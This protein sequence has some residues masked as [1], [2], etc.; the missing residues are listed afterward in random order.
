MVSVAQL[1][2]FV[3]SQ[4]IGRLRDREV[5]VG[6]VTVVVGQPGGW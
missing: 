1:G 6:D 3:R 2:C 5:V 4:D